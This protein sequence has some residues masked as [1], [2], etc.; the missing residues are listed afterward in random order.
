MAQVQTL[1]QLLGIAKE[2]TFKTPVAPSDSIPITDGGIIP[3]FEAVFDEARRGVAANV[4]EVVDGVSWGEASMEGPAYPDVIGHTLLAL[5]GA[6]AVVGAMDP[7]THTF[8]V[9]SLPPSYTIVD[10]LQTG[11][12][13][14]IQM[15]GC[16]CSEL[17]LSYDVAEGMLMHTS[18]WTGDGPTKSTV[19]VPAADVLKPWPA[20]FGTVTS[21]GLSGRV[22]AAE[23]TFS[24]DVERVHTGA[25]SRGVNSINVGALDIRGTLDL[26]ADDLADFDLAV[27]GTRQLLTV[28]FD[29]VALS[30]SIL[31]TMT[32]CFLNASPIEFDHG[33]L[34]LR[35]RLTFRGIN[36]T[37]D[38]GPGEVALENDVA[39]F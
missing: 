22:L 3:Q 30:R 32:D 28:L 5:F 23:I 16:R 10:E 12:N 2:V 36:N 9:A 14:D 31:I 8:N 35:N 37:T 25:A 7:F 20:Y 33:N 11:A 19:V 6:V 15:A 27:A 21:A 17:V 1:D 26:Q 34:G 38:A 4:F 29:D 24:R 39:A 18:Q 13:L